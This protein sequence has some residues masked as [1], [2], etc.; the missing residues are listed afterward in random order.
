MT[1]AGLDLDVVVRRGTF[2][3]RTTLRATPGEVV[4]VV[5]ANG[6]GKT[7]LLHTIAGLLRCDEG[8]IELDGRVLDAPTDGVF[9]PPEDRH[10]GVV[11][12][13]PRLFGHLD[14]LGNVAFGLRARNVARAEALERAAGWLDRLAIGD[15]AHRRADQLSGGQ[16]RR[17][18]LARALVTEPALLLLDEP[19]TSLDV[20]ARALVVDE[21]AE[22]LAGYDGIA[23]VVTHDQADAER[24]ANRTLELG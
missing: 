2:T 4:A 16:A 21:L 22:H 13:E 6:T 11:F 10:V 19:A 1:A 5:G 14:V 24:L 17:V 15:L 7:T 12:Q 20:D 9:V 18:A 23:L 3:L 8:R